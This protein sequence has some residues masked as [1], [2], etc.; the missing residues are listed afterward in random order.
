MF[1]FDEFEAFENLVE[2]GILPPTLFSYLR[3]LMQHGNGLNFI[4]VGTRRLE[5]MTTDYWSVLFNIALYRKISFLTG[6]RPFA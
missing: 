2:K 3:H 5:E 1:V 6:K 4:F